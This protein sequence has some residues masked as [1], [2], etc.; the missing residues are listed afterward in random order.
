MSSLALP[1][2]TG[3]TGGHVGEDARVVPEDLAIGEADAD[4]DDLL[5]RSRG[6]GRRPGEGPALPEAA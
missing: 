3:F 1:G 4:D 6:S 5:T 2:L